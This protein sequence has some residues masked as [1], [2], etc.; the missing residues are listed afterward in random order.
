MRG[1]K[2]E[3]MLTSP[4]RCCL[5][6]RHD[7]SRLC[8][9]TYPQHKRALPV[10]RPPPPSR[11]PPSNLSPSLTPPSCPPRT[12]LPDT[13]PHFDHHLSHPPLPS[14]PPLMHTLTHLPWTA[15]TLLPLLPPRSPQTH[16]PAPPQSHSCSR[17]SPPS[18]PRR[19]Q[20]RT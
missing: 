2:W 1:G 4:F 13:P 8:C 6:P 9:P 14:L 15:H 10:S 3:G 19:T 5:C 20:T 12:L 11:P 7:C 18:W 16:S 17:A